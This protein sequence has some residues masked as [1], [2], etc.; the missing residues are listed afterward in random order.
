[1][2]GLKKNKRRAIVKENAMENLCG[3]ALC[4]TITSEECS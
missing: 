3:K 2:D 4:C 1:M